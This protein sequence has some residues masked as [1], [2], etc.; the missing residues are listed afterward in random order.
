MHH[1]YWKFTNRNWSLHALLQ[2][3]FQVGKYNANTQ[4]IWDSLNA[5]H[6]SQYFAL[7]TKCDVTSGLWFQN[8]FCW[9]VLQI[10][11][12]IQTHLV[13]SEFLSWVLRSMLSG[14]AYNVKLFFFHLHWIYADATKLNNP[15]SSKSLARLA[16]CTFL[17]INPTSNCCPEAGQVLL[18]VSSTPKDL[19]HQSHWSRH[20]W[21]HRDRVLRIL[22][23]LTKML[24]M[25]Q[26]PTSSDFIQRS[27]SPE[28][29]YIYIYKYRYQICVMSHSDI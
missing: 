19:P 24:H 20:T 25:T 1:M 22:R 12:C 21:A 17:Y 15:I 26:C 18:D 8:R 4:S 27:K 16:E 5:D 11:P 28:T 6:S 13:F 29:H 3:C 7:F 10:R 23:W 2:P 9:L 14:G